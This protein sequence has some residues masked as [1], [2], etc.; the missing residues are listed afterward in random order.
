MPYFV[1]VRERGRAWDWAMPMRSQV[2]W[3]AHAAF[4]DALAE[5]GFILAGGPLGDEDRAARVITS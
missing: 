4:M 3:D 2:Q 5:E 1:I